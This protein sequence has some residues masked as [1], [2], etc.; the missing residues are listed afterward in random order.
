MQ[1]LDLEKLIVRTRIGTYFYT[2]I[3]YYLTSD[4]VIQ[5]S[6][7]SLFLYNQWG[8]WMS[9]LVTSLLKTQRQCNEFKK[10]VYS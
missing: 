9:D 4:I 5:L 2:C 1:V 10:G 3:Y 8:T 7:T 6:N